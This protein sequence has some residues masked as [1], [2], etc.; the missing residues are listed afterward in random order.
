MSETRREVSETRREV[1]GTRRELFRTSVTAA[2]GLTVGAVAGYAAA[3][4]LIATPPVP[5]NAGS[6]VAV[7]DPKN[8]WYLFHFEADSTKCRL[9]NAGA[10]P[11]V[12]DASKLDTTTWFAVSRQLISTGSAT[13]SYT[14]SDGSPGTL[15]IGFDVDGY[16]DPS[17]LSTL[18]TLIKSDSSAQVSGSWNEI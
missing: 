3:E 9:Y 18:L 12:S 15:Q 16:L 13:I 8:G 4:V 17:S 5:P 7:H 11:T 1:S 6:V 2:L 10:T 14:K